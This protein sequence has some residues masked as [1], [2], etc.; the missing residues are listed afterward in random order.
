MKSLA[1]TLFIF[2]F[3]AGYRANAQILKSVDKQGKLSF[4]SSTPVEDIDAHSESATSIINTVT[5]SV[6]VKVRIN[7]F[8]FKNALMQEHFNE[9]YLESEKYPYAVF[10]GKIN[11]HAVLATEGT[12]KVT[13]NGILTM[14]GVEKNTK[15]EGSLT[16]KGD[17]ISLQSSFKV[18][19]SDHKIDVPKLVMTKIAEEIACKAEITYLPYKKK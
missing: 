19:L 3:F 16:K 12:S 2:L 7:S 4:F 15:M 9:N 6:I 18:K 17:E 13:S 8:Q 14:H 5:D 11:E 1:L 10:R